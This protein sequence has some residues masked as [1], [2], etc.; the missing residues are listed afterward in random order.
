[1]QSSWIWIILF[2]SGPLFAQEGLDSLRYNKQL[3]GKAAPFSVQ[4]KA[5]LSLPFIDDFSQGDPYPDP[6]KWADNSVYINEG[7]PLNPPSIG[8]ATFDGLRPNGRPYTFSRNAYGSS[9]T[10]TSQP[11]DLSPYNATDSI[12]LSFFY[13]PKGRGNAP[14]GRDSLVLE[15]KVNDSTWAGMWRTVPTGLSTDTFQQQFIA[16]TEARWFRNDF[17]FRFRN[18]SA[19]S[20]NIDH[21]HVDYIE[22]DEGR[23][24]VNPLLNDVAFTRNGRSLL[25]RYH[26]MPLNQFVGF[27]QDELADS[28]FAYS[29]NHFNVIKNTTFRYDAR[30]NCTGQLISSNFFQTINYPPFADTTL[31]EANYKNDIISTVGGVSCDSLVITTRYFLNNSPPDPATS[32]NDT[33]RHQ[34]RFYNYFA[35]DDGSAEVAYRLQGQSA[36]VAQEYVVNKP[37]SLQAVLVHWAHVD[38]DISNDLVNLVVWQRLDRPSGTADI[39]L[40]RK[41]LIFPEYKDS[42]N[43]FT[44]YRLDSAVF[45]TDTFYIGFQQ[46]GTDNLRIGFDQ[47]VDAK[48]HL[49]FYVSGSWQQSSLPGA[50]MMRPVLGDAIPF[51][52]SVPEQPTFTTLSAYPNPTT[53]LIRLEGIEPGHGLLTVFDVTGRVVWQGRGQTQLALNEQSAGIYFIRYEK[54]K[55]IAQTKVL[56][57]Q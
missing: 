19:K 30:E 55:Q 15:F 36:Q 32:F 47:N 11:I 26:S 38:K 45:V 25:K 52:V 35:Y 57:S 14:E 39:V 46:V 27:E 29:T 6:L 16:L 13:Q 18:Y 42:L 10:L 5:P 9:D 1:M 3:A 17:Q 40:Y 24:R 37:D 54:G 23:T 2:L 53:G 49:Y 50:V 51:G 41:D 48:E 33:V 20:G 12:Y 43:G 34:Q 7:F 28:L 4:A 21:W 44:T 56:K 22:L 31:L 8:V